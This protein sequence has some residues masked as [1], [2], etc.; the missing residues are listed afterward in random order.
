MDRLAG[1]SAADLLL[2]LLHSESP[3]LYKIL[4]F[5]RAIGLNLS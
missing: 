3:K 1:A 5:L 4:V 2:T